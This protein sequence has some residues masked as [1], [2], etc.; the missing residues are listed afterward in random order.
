[1]TEW[2]ECGYVRIISNLGAFL[3]QKED[4]SIATYGSNT[5]GG[6][7]PGSADA[8]KKFKNIFA[9]IGGDNNAHNNPHCLGTYELIYSPPFSPAPPMLPPL[10]PPPTPPPLV[11]WPYPFVDW[12]QPTTTRPIEDGLPING[13]GSAPASNWFRPLEAPLVEVITLAGSVGLGTS[14]WE[15]VVARIDGVGTAARFESAKEISMTMD[16]N[17]V[18][19]II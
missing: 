17:T 4:G 2:D 9:T 18:P 13:G 16:G 7:G 19:H 5:F 1:M 14:F 15:P 10:L 12:L 3:A 11:D 8:S 6:E